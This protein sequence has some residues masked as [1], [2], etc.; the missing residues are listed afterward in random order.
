[1]AVPV[2]LDHAAGGPLAPAAAEAVIS[3][4]TGGFGNPSGSHQV[5]RRAR[6]AVDD[7]RDVMA[8]FL[9]VEPGGIIFTSGGTEADNLGV[10]GPLV[11]RPGAVVTTS[12][13]HPAVL[14]AAR[15]SGREVRTVAVGPDGL[16]DLD[17][18]DRALEGEVAV[19]SVQL[20]NHE[21]GVVQP[22]E[23]IA[24]RV[25]RRS[26]G[27][28]VHTD[29]VQAAGWLDLP[30]AAGSADL[31]TVSG[32]K[33]GGPQGAGVLA[34]RG[35]VE[36]APVVHGGGQERERRSGT[37][38]VAAIVGLAAAAS[39][40]GSSS[41]RARRG[42]EV[43]ARRDRL[44]GLVSASVPDAVRTA[45]HSPLAPGHCHFTFP[46][47]ES[48]ALLF[49]LDREGVCASAGAACASGAIEP[50]PVLLAM[51]VDRARA[52]SALRLTLGPTTTD[53]DVERAAAAVATAVAALGAR[54]TAP[55]SRVQRE[56]PRPVARQVP[57]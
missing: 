25:R 10:L 49:L 47:V 50:S 38:N 8:D 46:G 55:T 57:A 56:A 7:A 6:R 24:R 53:D 31:V 23:R 44:A 39:S 40:L 43:A 33:I 42:A 5:A 3:W 51:G 35:G 27:A 54:D 34:V 11:S 12:V 17:R 15:A 20:V 16:V 37:H 41:E 18:L 30:R 52:G 28:V 19:V 45:A 2:Y 4:L 14:E 1:M 32:H 36:L 29:A 48:E 22:L 26:P 21:T 9:G 13:E